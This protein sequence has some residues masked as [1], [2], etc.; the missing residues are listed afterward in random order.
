M[1]WMELDLVKF[2]RDSVCYYPA[3]PTPVPEGDTPLLG[4]RRRASGPMQKR[5]PG[6]SIPVTWR[7]EVTGDKGNGNPGNNK[8]DS[9]GIMM[10]G[11]AL[12][13]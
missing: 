7:R 6:A 4:R 12:R 3:S 11:L 5:D 8:W 1:A 10:Y 2:D 13:G 9:R